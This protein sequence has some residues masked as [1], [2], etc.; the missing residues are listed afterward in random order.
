MALIPHQVAITTVK[1]YT[2]ENRLDITK[3]TE[4]LNTHGIVNHLHSFPI[5]DYFAKPM[6]NPEYS[7][8]PDGSALQRGDYFVDDQG[9]VWV[10]THI[11]ADPLA[12]NWHSQQA[13]TI[14]LTK[15]YTKDEVD[16]ELAKKQNALTVDQQAVVDAKP[17]TEALK[18][19][20]TGI[21]ATPETR[22][23]HTDSTANKAIIRKGG[24]WRS[25]TDA[26]T[27]TP[28]IGIYGSDQ[29]KGQFGWDGS[30]F[31]F[32]WRDNEAVDKT[33]I[34]N[35]IA[36]KEYVDDKFSKTMIITFEDD[37]TETIKVGG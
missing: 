30:H 33:L 10:F 15:Y 24:F 36:K 5:D 19:K 20:L 32:T 3:L 1:K 18:T 9:K 35:D 23:L 16:A 13:P 31:G 28:Y 22:L 34:L 7:T 8:R 4:Y 25:E 14:D 11:G 2:K 12:S 21:T 29:Y 27:S 26:S 6:P 17:F 37:T